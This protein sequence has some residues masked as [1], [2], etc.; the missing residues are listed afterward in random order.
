MDWNGDKGEVL[1]QDFHGL[2]I[3][4]MEVAA[5]RTFDKFPS[6]RGGRE[7]EWSF[8][9]ASLGWMKMIPRS[10][11]SDGW[12]RYHRGGF[13]W[14]DVRRVLT[15]PPAGSHQTSDRLLVDK[16]GMVVRSSRGLPWLDWTMAFKLCLS[17]EHGRSKDSLPWSWISLGQGVHGG[18][19][20]FPLAS[21]WNVPSWIRSKPHQ[22]PRWIACHLTLRIS[23]VSRSWCTY[24]AI[25][26]PMY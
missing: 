20:I 14:M 19:K 4:G 2:W 11:P 17:L 26:P 16:E 18:K 12:K 5:R 15:R 1:R 3:V 7:Q 24:Y 6:V 22:S 8:Q 9:Q 13:P 25:A 10:L 21:S 23:L